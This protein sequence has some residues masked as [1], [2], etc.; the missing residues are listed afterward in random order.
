MPKTHTVY[1]FEITRAATPTGSYLQTTQFDAPTVAEHIRRSLTPDARMV[2]YKKT[3]RLSKPFLSP[4]QTFLS[5]KLG[6]DKTDTRTTIVYDEESL[7][8]VE[9]DEIVPLGTYI[10]YIVHLETQRVVAEATSEIKHSTTRTL[11]EKFLNET[12]SAYRFDVNHLADNTAFETW[13]E[14]VGHVK[15]FDLDIVRPN[16]TFDDWPNDLEEMVS[17][18]NADAAGMKMRNNSGGGLNMR[19]SL[20]ARIVRFVASHEK[21][22]SFRATA[23]DGRKYM[24]QD[25]KMAKQFETEGDIESERMFDLLRRIFLRNT[26]DE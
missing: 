20:L 1:F 19:S 11:M 25:N 15:K 13:L 17:D 22:G 2:Y 23:S 5:G 18:T 8:F 16:P 24:S 6:F 4:D 26:S 7:D 10:H 21:Y 14:A 12:R 3:W 9:K